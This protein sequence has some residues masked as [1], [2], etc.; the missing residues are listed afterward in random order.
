M[1]VTLEN[2]W[3]GRDKTHPLAL[4]PDIRRNAA[5]TVELVNQL[6]D[7]AEISGVKLD[8]TPDGNPLSSGWRP[9]AVNAG[10]AG[11]A[12]NSLHMTGEA[13]DIYDPDGELDDWLMTDTGQAA[14]TRLGLWLEH[15]GSTRR[16]SH[17]Q[18]KPPRSGRRV[19]YP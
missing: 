11:A 13:A 5:R 19:F 7:E 1:H 2:Y 18:T 17:V 3:M 8:R 15:P 12:K 4:T 10:V 14:L 6:L 16:W 9:P